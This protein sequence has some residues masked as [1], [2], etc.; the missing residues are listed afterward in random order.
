MKKTLESNREIIQH[1]Q[2]MYQEVIEIVKKYKE[3]Y[4]KASFLVGLQRYG[5]FKPEEDQYSDVLA[6]SFSSTAL[7][8]LAKDGVALE[9]SKGEGEWPGSIATLVEVK[10]LF[11]KYLFIA[12]DFKER[13]EENLVEEVPLYIQNS[14][15]YYPDREESLSIVDDLK[16]VIW[17]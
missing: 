3:M 7:V 13:I 2:K 6:K 9:R 1:E 11:K 8:F 12:D 4:P 5:S 16:E 15:Q 10:G 14:E 17:I